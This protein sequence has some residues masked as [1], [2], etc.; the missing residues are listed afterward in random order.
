MASLT[1]LPNELISQV[2]G[3]LDGCCKDIAALARTCRTTHP[4]AN[5]ALYHHAARHHPQM[6]C[7]ASK[8]GRLGAVRKLLAA[9]AEASASFLQLLPGNQPSS[10]AVTPYHH[11]SEGQQA[12]TSDCKCDWVPRPFCEEDWAVQLQNTNDGMLDEDTFAGPA[13]DDA[14]FRPSPW[15]DPN[16]ELPVPRL[17]GDQQPRFGRS[18][19]HRKS[20]FTPLHLAAMGGHVEVAR[21]LLDHGADVN[22]TGTRICNCERLLLSER[23]PRRRRPS[24]SDDTVPR[25]IAV[26]PLHLAICRAQ[27]AVAKL[28][29]E[30]GASRDYDT[31]K[32]KTHAVHTAAAHGQVEVLKILLAGDDTNKINMQ[33]W[34]GLTPLCYAYVNRQRKAVRWL[35]DNK[36]DVNA[37]LGKGL[38]LLHLAC[39]DGEFSFARRLIEAG[40]DVKISCYISDAWGPTWPLELC[41]LLPHSK[42]RRAYAINDSKLHQQNFEQSRLDLMRTMLA[43]GASPGDRR[44]QSASPDADLFYRHRGLSPLSIAA[45]HNCIPMLELLLAAGADLSREGALLIHEAI[46]P[47]CIKWRARKSSPLE[48][49][50]W[51]VAHGV[52]TQSQSRIMALAAVAVV[53]QPA[54]CTWKEEVLAW[55]IAH[56]LNPVFD[57]TIH[58]QRRVY[59]H[60][61]DTEFQKRLHP[62]DFFDWLHKS[63]SRSSLRDVSFPSPLSHFHCPWETDFDCHYMND[64]TSPLGTALARGDKTSCRMLIQTDAV[65]DMSEAFNYFMRSA[66]GYWFPRRTWDSWWLRCRPGERESLVARMKQNTETLAL[67]IELDV[68]HQIK[69]GESTFLGLVRAVGLHAS[70]ILL[71]VPLPSQDALYKELKGISHSSWFVTSKHPRAEAEDDDELR[72]PHVDDI[73]TFCRLRDQQLSSSAGPAQQPRS[74][75]LAFRLLAA[76][77]AQ[78]WDAA[79]FILRHR[80][81]LSWTLKSDG[82]GDGDGCLAHYA[83]VICAL[84]QAPSPDVMGI[85]NYV[86][87]V[88]RWYESDIRFGTDESEE[89]IRTSLMYNA[90]QGSLDVY[91]LFLSRDPAEARLA[92]SRRPRD[93]LLHLEE[94]AEYIV[95]EPL[96]RRA[97]PRALNYWFRNV[98]RNLELLNESPEAGREVRRRLLQLLKA[99][100][101]PQDHADWEYTVW[102][103]FSA[104]SKPT[105]WNSWPA[106]RRVVESQTL[107]GIKVELAKDVIDGYINVTVKLEG[108]RETFRCENRF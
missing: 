47:S 27:G 106:T 98:C 72:K 92:F 52:S 29:L 68:D 16:P 12:V 78:N 8:H 84:E 22:A 18:L 20:R 76:I 60:R 64:T 83:R 21:L 1:D 26:T 63:Y 108:A 36:A 104:K 80:P 96:E 91:A 15:H 79:Y 59:Q 6:L 51:L 14:P 11:L 75:D 55:L 44:E 40:A 45:A 24:N 3:D 37:R 4:V 5:E 50:Q 9:G 69:G 42:S 54:D 17:D 101:L 43:A 62:F 2:L 74:W 33:D 94:V 39:I 73:A 48:T 88:E 103:F 32:W 13:G 71:Q 30:S 97:M 102:H 38:T 95:F 99:G 61:M 49:L 85:E 105:E 35:L 53:E 89:D 58:R 82:D 66:R 93:S 57:V 65:L 10:Q 67:L 34:N 7:W 90:C 77:L 100:G 31:A 46:Y 28:L 23:D 41:A 87:L 107:A 81:D 56:G 19:E 70:S 25:A 86:S